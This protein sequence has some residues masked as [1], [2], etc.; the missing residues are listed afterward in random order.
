MKR[1]AVFFLVATL[2][3]GCGKTVYPDMVRDKFKHELDT[4]EGW[5]VEKWDT[6]EPA[7]SSYAVTVTHTHGGAWQRPNAPSY[8]RGAHNLLVPYLGA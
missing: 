5:R 1:G 6:C 3:A 4:A 7:K 8:E 2:L